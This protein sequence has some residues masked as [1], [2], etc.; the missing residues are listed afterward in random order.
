L[1][2]GLLDW[3]EPAEVIN[4]KIRGLWPWPGAYT[5]YVSNKTGKECQVI[6]AQASPFAEA[7]AGQGVPGTLDGGLNVVCGE[8][9]L[10][11]IKIKPAGSSLMDFT[12]FANG[13]GTAP[14]DR[15]VSNKE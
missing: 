8:G 6:I 7:S 9:A 15:F 3:S 12:A 14:G 1:P 5:T 4:N 13:R 11:I 2:V 10:K